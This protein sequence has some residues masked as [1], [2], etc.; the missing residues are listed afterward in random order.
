MIN[1]SHG[2]FVKSKHE[3]QKIRHVVVYVEHASTF[4]III[5]IKQ[6]VR[7]FMT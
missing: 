6:C 4:L 2:V 7:D 1:T 3:N 5:V